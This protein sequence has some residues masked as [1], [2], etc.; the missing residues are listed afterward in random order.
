MNGSNRIF[1][2]IDTK[3]FISGVSEFQKEFL[4]FDFGLHVFGPHRKLAMHRV[5]ALLAGEEGNILVKLFL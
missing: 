1:S 2:E 4:K 3:V 5:A